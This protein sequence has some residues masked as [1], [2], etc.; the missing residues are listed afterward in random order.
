M[1]KKIII[2]DNTEKNRKLMNRRRKEGS[3]TQYII[4]SIIPTAIHIITAVLDVPNGYLA[5]GEKA[6]G[7]VNAWTDNKWLPVDAVLQKKYLEDIANYTAAT[8]T[9]A[10][11][12][13]W[14]TVHDDLKAL[15]RLIQ[16]EADKKPADAIEIIESFKLRVKKVAIHQIQVFGAVN[17]AEPGTI[18]LTAPGGKGQHCHDWWFSPDGI[19]YTRM[20]PTLKSTTQMVGLKSLSWAWFM[21][22]LIVAKDGTGLSDPIKIQ[23][24]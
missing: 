11:N 17:G 23:V 22:E 16:T 5:K 13:A 18:D 6:S 15:M 4:L 10:R 7:I 19:N 20:R 2:L 21:H 14:K 12:S 9:A 3:S 24:K 8:S 1:K